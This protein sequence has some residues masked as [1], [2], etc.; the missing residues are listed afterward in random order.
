MRSCPTSAPGC[1]ASPR[2]G[3]C[4]S[5]REAAASRLG[6]TTALQFLP[7]LLFGP[8]GGLLADRYPKRMLL[9]ISQAGMALL[10]LILG[11]LDVFDVVTLGWVYALA[12]G[13]GLLAAVDSP[14]R[15]S[16]VVDMVGR[17]DLPNAVGL[18]STAFH[19]ARIVGPAIAGLMIT[20]FGTGPVFLINALSFL[21]VIAGLLAMDPT[22]LRTSPRAPRAKG[23]IRDGVRYLR[24]RRDLM[25]VMFV[26]GV[27]ATLG[28]NFS[29]TMALMAT[30]VFGKGAQGYGLLA[31]MLGVGSVA[32]ALLAARR[33]RPTLALVAWSAVA[34]GALETFAAR[35][36]PT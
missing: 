14:T 24:T 11:L 13:L 22:K 9:L 2:T 33:Q 31:T 5:C 32:G 6:I 21:A 12:F 28:L 18:N 15:Q 1:S 4:W 25:L 35:C 27:V 34:F 36:P 17:E 26:V 8:W 23:Q 29:V 20:A 7:A 19:G 16:F 30:Q 10:A 3:S